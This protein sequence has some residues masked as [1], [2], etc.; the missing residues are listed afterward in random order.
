MTPR[1]AGIRALAIA[2]VAFSLACRSAVRETALVVDPTADVIAALIDSLHPPRPELLVVR[3]STLT[4]E[5]PSAR[6][7][8]QYRRALAAF[9]P[10]LVDD[11]ARVS[12]RRQSV[13]AA[14]L[15]GPAHILTS[16]EQRELFA[17]GVGHGWT[18]FGRRFPSAR[19]FYAFSPV[20]YSGDK[21]AALVFYHRSC[22]GRCGVGQLVLLRRRDGDWRV[23]RALLRYIS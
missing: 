16:A 12:A 10:E 5:L 17:G 20:V 9:P 1:T 23:E 3:D 19:G 22:G 6:T 2:S 11:L 14:T 7:T 4:F 18:L 13:Q 15:P 8:A 21:K